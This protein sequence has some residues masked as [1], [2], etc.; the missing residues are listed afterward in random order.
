MTREEVTA[1]KALA[2]APSWHWAEGML[3]CSD[4]VPDALGT[5]RCTVLD[6]N[7]VAVACL[8]VS[9]GGA[10]LLHWPARS[11]RCYPNIADDATIGVLLAR[12]MDRHPD[13]ALWVSPKSGGWCWRRAGGNAITPPDQQ[14]YSLGLVV[15]RGLAHDWG[16]NA[17]V[18]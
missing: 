15:A 11:S 7:G 12:L 13:S 4:D 18:K 6:V 16:L 8:G 2:A 17:N 3:V 5:R 14:S 1:A 10:P 9:S